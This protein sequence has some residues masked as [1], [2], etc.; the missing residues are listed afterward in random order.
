MFEHADKSQKIP[1]ILKTKGSDLIKKQ[2]GAF[3]DLYCKNTLNP[4]TIMEDPRSVF[5]FFQQVIP[6]CI[7]ELCEYS[8]K[9]LD[10]ISAFSVIQANSLAV[11]KYA[12]SLEIAYDKMP[13][14]LVERFG[15][16]SA[17][18]NPIGI[19]DLFEKGLIQK[20]DDL[21][22]VGYGAG[23]KYGAAV[24]CVP[25]GFKSGFVSTHL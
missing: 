21:A 25:D 17:T 13:M 5:M 15:D 8:G 16:V 20:G 9:Q 11:K 1:I 10:K 6:E 24:I 12:D 18:I 2:G 7:K 3:C 14:N 22:V 4:E 19:A 23:L